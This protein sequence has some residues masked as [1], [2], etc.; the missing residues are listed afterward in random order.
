MQPSRGIR[1]HRADGGKT[2]LKA[3]RGS[4]QGQGIGPGGIRAES[5]VEDVRPAVAVIVEVLVGGGGVGDE[6]FLPIAAVKKI[7]TATGV[8]LE[9]EQVC[10][11][12]PS[13]AR[14]LDRLRVQKGGI[15]GR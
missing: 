11:D 7:G 9:P 10:L 15:C 4:R 14:K 1:H 8:K 13:V 2:D 5:G 6:A 3:A 12:Q